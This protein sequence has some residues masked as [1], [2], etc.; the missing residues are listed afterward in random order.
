MGWYGE[1]S[2]RLNFL[3]EEFD[4]V[5]RFAAKGEN[6]NNAAADCHLA[7]VYDSILTAESFQCERSH[8]VS[9]GKLIACLQSEA[10]QIDKSR[11]S[12]WIMQRPDCGDNDTAPAALDG[13]E[14]FHPP[15]ANLKVTVNRL[16]RRGIALG[17]IL[18][19]AGA[20]DTFEIIAERLCFLF[21]RQYC[22]RRTLGR[23]AILPEKP[24][25]KKCGE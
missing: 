18:N 1:C 23:A 21:A 16:I 19:P 14:R 13:V 8:Q 24:R 4:A 25:G 12:R 11:R 6:I 2:D 22:Q 15:A 7:G 3:T 20:D 9:E 10:G 17:K 5:R